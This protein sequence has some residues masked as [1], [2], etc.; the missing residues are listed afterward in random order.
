MK[1]KSLLGNA[2]L[3]LAAMIWGT[4]FV[5]QR[6][7]MESIEPI[8][9]NAA[10]MTLSA[11]MIGVLAIL[12]TMRN[13]KYRVSSDETKKYWKNTVLGG[14]FCGIF[15]AAASIFQQMG[16]VY[17]SA[18][19]AGFI[20]AMYMLFVPIIHF[21][22]FRKKNSLFVWMAILMGLGGMYLLCVTEKLTLTFGDGLVFVCAILFSG[23][24]LCCD[25]FAPLGDAI[26]ISAI[27]FLTASVISWI[28]AFITETPT[29]EK[30]L[31]AVIPIVYCGIL[32]GGVGYTMQIVAQKHTDPTIA[33]LL[34]SLESVFAVLAGVLFL[35]ERMSPK[36]AVGCIIM[37][38]AIVLVQIPFPQK[39]NRV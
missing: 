19:K 30:L 36:E 18:G 35:N 20:T 13:K 15:L 10:R 12:L 16:L 32:S 21:L 7:G 26:G 11:V 27:Q 3:F 31:S 5:G 17:T 29:T 4:A 6:V 2:L 39:K 34:M 1:N 38:A 24:I 9:F 28:I 33:S 8:T 22:L 23:H 37:F 25:H 14:V